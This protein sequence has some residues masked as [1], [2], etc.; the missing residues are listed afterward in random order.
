MSKIGEEKGKMGC[1]VHQVPRQKD[2]PSVKMI[3][4]SWDVFDEWFSMRR[5]EKAST[6]Y[7]EETNGYP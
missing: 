5:P 6:N 2:C 1:V 3:T 4:L 7:P